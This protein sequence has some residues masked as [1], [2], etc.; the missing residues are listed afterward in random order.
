MVDWSPSIQALAESLA[1]RTTEAI[2]AL[3][4]IHDFVNAFIRNGDLA[5]APSTLLESRMTP[6]SRVLRKHM[7]SCG[8]VTTL[9]AALLRSQG[10]AVKLVHGT[11]RGSDHAWL[12]VWDTKWHRWLPFDHMESDRPG[13][14]LKPGHRKLAE[15][16]DWSEIRAL[17]VEAQKRYT[18]PASQRIQPMQ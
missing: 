18:P 12:E 4:S 16:A 1:Q 8:T 15:C 17:L 7:V 3:A 11:Y 6:A 13:D 14:A 2:T 5:I 10:H 9:S